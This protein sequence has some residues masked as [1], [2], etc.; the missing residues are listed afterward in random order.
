MTDANGATQPPCSGVTFDWVY[1]PGKR[2]LVTIY[3]SKLQMKPPMGQKMS[4]KAAAKAFCDSRP[5]YC[6][7]SSS[8]DEAYPYDDIN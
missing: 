7:T 8:M 6:K 1:K 2:Q 3:F 5:A 4:A